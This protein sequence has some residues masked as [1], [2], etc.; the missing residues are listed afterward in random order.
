MACPENRH[1]AHY[2]GTLSFPISHRRDDGETKC[3]AHFTYFLTSGFNFQ[4]W[5]PISS[6]Q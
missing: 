6:F 2:I 1:C 4:Y 5:V 3:P